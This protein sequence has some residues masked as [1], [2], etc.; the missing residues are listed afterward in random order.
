MEPWAYNVVYLFFAFAACGV[1]RIL[2]DS[3]IGEWF[4]YL[5]HLM[6]IHPDAEFIDD[7]NLLEKT[8]MP[9]RIKVAERASGASDYFIDITT[10]APTSGPM[11]WY[12]W[13]CVEIGVSRFGK[14]VKRIKVKRRAILERGK[15]VRKSECEPAKYVNSVVLA[16]LEV[17][18]FS[19]PADECYHATL[20]SKI[21]RNYGEGIFKV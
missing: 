3:I 5:R 14:F 15:K 11:V 18:K 12:H 2:H 10:P 8:Y 20:V 16:H 6:F 7:P 17:L 21:F 13:P 19:L 9:T 1:F 4:V